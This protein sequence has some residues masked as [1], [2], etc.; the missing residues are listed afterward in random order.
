MRDLPRAYPKSTDYLEVDD[1]GV[2]VSIDTRFKTIEIIVKGGDT[3][4][5]VG[6]N[7]LSGADVVNTSAS[8]GK[9]DCFMINSSVSEYSVDNDDKKIAFRCPPG[10]S[11]I[12]HINYFG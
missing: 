11:S 6:D 2:S 4:F 5:R 7:S 9:R 8:G 1:S 12:V 3:Y 10:V